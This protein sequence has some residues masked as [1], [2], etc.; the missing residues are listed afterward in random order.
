[1]DLVDKRL[2]QISQN[3][4]YMFDLITTIEYVVIDRKRGLFGVFFLGVKHLLSSINLDEKQWGC[5]ANR[6][7]GI[8]ALELMIMNSPAMYS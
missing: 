3:K 7:A 6:E 5:N 4:L 8:L 1:M 2:F